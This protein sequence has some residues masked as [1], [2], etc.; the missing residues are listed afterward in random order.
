[1]SNPGVITL[2]KAESRLG[3]FKRFVVED[4]IGESIHLHVDSMRI[5]FSILEFFEFS[6]MIRQSLNELDVLFGHS[7][8][9]FDEHFLKLCSPWLSSL[10][11]ITIE[12]VK[13][14]DL[15]CVVHAS[16]RK[17]LHIKKILPI[18]KVPAYQYLAGDKDAFL[19]YIQ[20]NY[21][22]TDNE[23]RLLDIKN[24][25]QKNGYPFNQQYI[26]LFNGQNIIRDGQHRAAILAH[27]HGIN[28]EI[29]VMR[30]HFTGNAHILHTRKN[31]TKNLFRWFLKKVYLRLKQLFN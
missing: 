3:R 16:Y 9:N 19:N 8:D 29:Q 22:N 21:F 25:I 27:L 4:N 30:F 11:K 15:S 12:S 17:D 31:N 7:I 23:T 14:S 20:Y 24:S 26:I 5:D 2:N 10:N 18:S 6:K 28:R 1:M 13:L